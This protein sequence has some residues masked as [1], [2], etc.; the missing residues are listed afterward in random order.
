MR[1]CSLFMAGVCSRTSKGNC[2]QLKWHSVI[3]SVYEL[4]TSRNAVAWEDIIPTEHSCTHLLHC[5]LCDVIHHRNLTRARISA[6]IFNAI[7][8]E[9]YGSS[10]IRT[11][12][13]ART[14]CHILQVLLTMLHSGEQCT[15]ECVRKLLDLQGRCHTTIFAV[16][17][18]CGYLRTFLGAV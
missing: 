10:D 2:C 15:M 7:K 6:I 5:I 12:L 18:T 8:L 1:P 16:V 3:E 17:F 14:L 9:L 4:H 11:R 13:P